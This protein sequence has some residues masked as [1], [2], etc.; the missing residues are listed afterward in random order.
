MHLLFIFAF[1][2]L[3]CMIYFAKIYNF[4]P[5]EG[6]FLASNKKTHILTALESINELK[7]T[8][9]DVTSAQHVSVIIRH[10]KFVTS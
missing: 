8:P 3:C 2:G 6:N 4:Q 7:D 10:H 9:R 1:S 5:N